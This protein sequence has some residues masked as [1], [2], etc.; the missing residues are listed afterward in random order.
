MA[1]NVGRIIETAGKIASPASSRGTSASVVEQESE[2][3]PI[4]DLPPQALIE[5]ELQTQLH[6]ISEN[7]DSPKALL[8]I[9]N[10]ALTVLEL[11]ELKLVG[12]EDN[13]SL[14]LSSLLSLLTNS[15]YRQRI[16]ERLISTT[17]NFWDESWDQAW[18][19]DAEPLYS[20]RQQRIVRRRSL[21]SFWTKEWQ[22]LPK[23]QVE[24]AIQVVD[25]IANQ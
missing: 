2:T 15:E 18:S 9:R 5:S 11:N 17:P 19:K 12:Q 24:H 14:D 13:R 4:L 25:S 6:K 23:E 16:V 21:I 1:N 8:I 20:E 7:I 10:A 22:S 3:P